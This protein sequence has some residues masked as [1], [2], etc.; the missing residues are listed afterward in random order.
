MS[1]NRKKAV[2]VSLT[3]SE[4]ARLIDLAERRGMTISEY[5][6]Q[7]AIHSQREA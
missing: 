3:E 6:R 1:K 5:I 2:Y 4:K 7:M